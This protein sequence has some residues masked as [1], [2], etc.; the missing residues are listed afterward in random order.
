MAVFGGWGE[1]L[2][3]LVAPGYHGDIDLLVIDPDLDALDR[4]V[5]QRDENKEKRLSHKRAFEA[6]GVLVE[7]FL[8][9]RSPEPCTL[10]WDTLLYKWPDI[11]PVFMHG[12]PVVATGALLA[13]RRDYSMIAEARPDCP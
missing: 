2:P 6:S 13:F 5:A 10:F 8:V 9:T 7:L 11:G 12:L 4:Y 3:G 1:E